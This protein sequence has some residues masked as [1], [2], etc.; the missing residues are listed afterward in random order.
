MV[1]LIMKNSLQWWHQNNNG[2]LTYHSSLSTNFSFSF[3]F[4]FVIVVVRVCAI[5]F[6]CLFYSALFFFQNNLFTIQHTQTP[7]FSFCSHQKNKQHTLA[8][9]NSFFF[10]FFVCI[11]YK[12]PISQRKIYW[13][14]ITNNFKS[15][16]LDI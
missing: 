12:Y 2:Q 16:C 1:K 9:C 13:W 6:V 14:N 15:V 3:V 11:I 4:F 8:Y 10:C 5:F 7:I